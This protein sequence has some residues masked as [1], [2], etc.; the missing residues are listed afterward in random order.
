MWCGPQERVQS[1]EIGTA[2]QVLK[3]RFPEAIGE[4]KGNQMFLA[5]KR[6]VCLS[7]VNTGASVEEG[8]EFLEQLRMKPHTLRSWDSCPGT[9]G[10][11]WFPG[12]HEEKQQFSLKGFFSVS[13]YYLQ[14]EH[15][16]SAKSKF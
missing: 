8:H 10:G 16:E 1:H 4:A 2:S 7:P 6:R 14:V 12:G 15:L 13:N 5:R 3:N 9:F 11:F